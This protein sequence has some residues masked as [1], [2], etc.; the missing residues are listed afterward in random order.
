MNVNPSFSVEA[1]PS[2]Q[3]SAWARWLKKRRWFL[4]FVV[5][6]TLLAT[7]YY[8]LI[9]SDVYISESR[10]VIKSPDQKRSQMSTLAN[11]VQTTGL[12][13]G[14]EQAN[15]VLTY[16][17]SRDALKALERNI[18]VRDKFA[19]GQADL[20]SRFPQPLSDGGFESLFRY[21][22]KMVEARMDAEN[23]TAIIKV[24]AFAPQDAYI[25]NRELLDLSEGLVNRLNGRAQNKGIAEAQKQVDQATQRAKAARVALGQYRNAQGLIDPSKQAVGVLEIANTMIGE[26]AALQAQLDLMQRLAPGNPSIPALRNKINAISMQIASQDGR[27]VGNDNGIA[28]KL[29]G[30]ESLL[31][32]QEFATQSLNAANAALVQARADAQRQQFYLERVVDPNTPDTPLLPKRLINI[33]IVAAAALCLYF[34]AWMFTVGVLEHAPED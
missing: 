8:G 13:G 20:L 30:Y 17:R 14:Q 22:G 26:R 25:I 11:L 5:T 7:L 2:V 24:K 28:S 21:Y 23:G 19:T 29:G 27:V 3:R 18:A 15:E 32:E 33:L 34:I 9:A 12:S 1:D 4:L 10:F 6:P 16:V 31:V